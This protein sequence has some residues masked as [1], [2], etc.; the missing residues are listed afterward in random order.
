[1]QKT[2][3][4]NIL[5]YVGKVIFFDET[6]DN[7]DVYSYAGKV[8]SAIIEHDGNHKL[9][10]EVS[11]DDAHVFD[12]NRMHNIKLFQVNARPSESLYFRAWTG[13]S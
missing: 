7:L 12:L 8:L 4:E 5:N 9:C 2:Q 1:M 13:I 11:K 10:V 6:Q 3:I